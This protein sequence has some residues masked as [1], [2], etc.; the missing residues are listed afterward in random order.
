MTSVAT[1]GRRLHRDETQHLQQ[2]VLHDVAHR[3]DGLVEAAAVCDAEVLAHRDLH[4][5]D[6]L[7]VPDRLEDRVGE[8]EVEDVLDGHLPEEVVDPVELRLVDE[9]ME[10]GVE[11]ARGGKV[12]P[13]R[14]LDH[15]PGVL[16]ES[17]LRQAADNGAEER[18]RDLEVE[19]WAVRA[20]DRLRHLGV[21]GVV[22]EVAVDVGESL[23]ELPEDLVIELLAGRDDRLTCVPDELL[24]RPVVERDSDDRAA[25][26]AREPRDGRAT[27]TS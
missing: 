21:R 13:E 26:E 23:R 17:L 16:G 19:D 9:R 7:P 27:G 3:P 24:E 5:G 22:G 14:L 12:V 2:V 18:R 15:D 25:R 11:F 1:S 6:E 10:L 4:R 8:A 20:L